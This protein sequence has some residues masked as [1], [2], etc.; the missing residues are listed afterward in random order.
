MHPALVHFNIKITHDITHAYGTLA[1]DVLYI[2][3][4]F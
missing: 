2:F 1:Y 3:L 4:E